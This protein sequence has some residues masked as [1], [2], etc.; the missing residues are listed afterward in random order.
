MK[1]LVIMKKDVS[2]GMFLMMMKM[3][4][5]RIV[6]IL[7]MVFLMILLIAMTMMPALMIGVTPILDVNTTKEIVMTRMNAL[8]ILV[9]AT[10]DVFIQM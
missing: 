9:T 10:Q 8:M 7:S 4:V 3:N 6:V 2:T 5:P 1:T